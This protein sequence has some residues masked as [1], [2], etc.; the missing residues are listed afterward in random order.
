MNINTPATLSN[1]SDCKA[2][3]YDDEPSYNDTRDQNGVVHVAMKFGHGISCDE[4]TNYTMTVLLACDPNIPASNMQFVISPSST[5]CN[6]VISGAVSNAC[7]IFSLGW[8][9]G[10]YLPVF[11]LV[12]LVAG[13]FMTFYGHLFFDHVLFLF[14]AIT[15]G[16]ITLVYFLIICR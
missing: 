2:I 14:G 12:F 6:I 7:P 8:M 4:Y 5:P 3:L 10:N 1:G 15:I 11:T 16:G 13:Y 9:I